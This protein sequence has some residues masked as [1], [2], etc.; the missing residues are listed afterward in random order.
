[1]NNKKEKDVSG[2]RIGGLKTA[3]TNKKRDPDHYHKIGRLGGLKS[4]G[5]GFAAMTP[6]QRSEAGR[7]GG[8]NSRKGKKW[9]EKNGTTKTD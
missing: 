6:E 2:N 3:E 4:R 1:M 8:A 7:K 5:G 9:S